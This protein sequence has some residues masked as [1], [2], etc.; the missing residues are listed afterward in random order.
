MCTC[1]C[2]C[3]CVCVCCRHADVASVLQRDWS[4]RANLEAL[5]TGP[6]AAASDD[7]AAART[8]FMR[9]LLYSL[10]RVQQQS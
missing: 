10:L 2:V 8:A 1:V 6:A 5:L 7:D 3:V 9:R 4:V